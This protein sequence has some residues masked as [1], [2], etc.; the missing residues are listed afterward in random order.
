MLDTL[1]RRIANVFAGLARK[2][3]LTEDD[4]NEMLREV[5]VALLEAD[6]NLTVV[7]D[8][9]KRVKEKAVGEEVY[10]SLT[11]DQTLVK[12]VRDE[13][14]ALLGG[15][16]EKFNWSPQPPTVILLSGLQGSGKTTTA[17][18]LAMWLTKQDKKPLMAAC[19]IQRP[20]AIKQLEVLGEQIGVPVFSK[21][22]GSSPV[23]IAKEAVERAKYL[24]LDTVIVDTAGRLTIDD[25]LMDELANIY[26]AVN[27]DETFLVLDSTTGQ[28]AVNVANA[29][30]QKVPLTGAIFTKLDSDTRG[31]AVLSVRQSTGVPVRFIGIGEQVEAIDQFYPERMAERIIGMGDVMGIIEKAEAAFKEEDAEALE[32]KL[33]KGQFDFSDLLEQFRMMRKMGPFK[34]IIKMLPG[35][36]QMIP[37]EALDAMDDSHVNKIEAI[38]FSM[39]AK[40]RSNPDILNGSRRKRIAVGS[41]ASVEEVNALVKQ[42]Y[43]MRRNMKAL[44]KMQ[45]KMKRRPPPRRPGPNR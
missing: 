39:T 9:I 7:K 30:H 1:T 10:G 14:A 33:G 29:F 22:D 44:S 40:E 26:K 12:I 2:G 23:Q 45:Q 16:P 31:G 3:R 24:M 17:A 27:P 36:N 13:L 34:N 21:T 43:E 18:K 41:G 11:A 6:V 5:R 25:A 38:I 20:A 35:V 19:D 28:E 37:E 4:V 32:A 8:F 42:L 15:Q